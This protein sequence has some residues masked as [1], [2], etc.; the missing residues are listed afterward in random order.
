MKP[1]KFFMANI[2]AVACVV[3]L[4]AGTLSNAGAA[5]IAN[6]AAKTALEDIKIVKV[7]DSN[8]ESE[9]L[10][11]KKPVILEISSTG[12]SHHFHWSR[13][14]TSSSSKRL[15]INCAGFPATIV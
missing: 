13:I 15:R 12:L 1:K 4:V 3:A 14:C 9:I 2:A 11:S 6:G 7:N 8:F 5:Q 10:Q